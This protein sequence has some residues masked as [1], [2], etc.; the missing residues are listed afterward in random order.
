MFHL[1]KKVAIARLV[2]GQRDTGQPVTDQPATDQRTGAGSVGEA[3]DRTL[4]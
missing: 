2:T 3:I 4:A 1:R